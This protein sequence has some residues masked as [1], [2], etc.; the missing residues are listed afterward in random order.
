M[1]RKN[2]KYGNTWLVKKFA[3]FP[4]YINKKRIWFD[5]YY[6]LMAWTHIC[7]GPWWSPQSSKTV[8]KYTIKIFENIKD[9]KSYCRKIQSNPNSFHTI[10]KKL[11]ELK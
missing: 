10:F 1:S 9:Y 7:N 8:K 5:Y 2:R 6:E 11:K 4:I 3:I